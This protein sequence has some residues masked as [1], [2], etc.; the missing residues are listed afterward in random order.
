MSYRGEMYK[1]KYFVYK[2]FSL[3]LIRASF[4]IN[5]IICM[6]PNLFSGL[7][8]G[9][10]AYLCSLVTNGRVWP[11]WCSWISQQQTI[12]FGNTAFWTTL[13]EWSCEAACYHIPLLP[14]W[15]IP[16][17]GARELLLH[18]CLKYSLQLL[19]VYLIQL[20][21]VTD[22]FTSCFNFWDYRDG[23]NLYPMSA[24]KCD[25]G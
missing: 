10:T 8:A 2:I 14:G 5:L 15:S 13:L 3:H 25:M 20:R 17:G 7:T 12:D 16:E 9:L 21:E 1:H 18:C 22:S 19:N 6:H 11:C 4:L 23:G 24:G